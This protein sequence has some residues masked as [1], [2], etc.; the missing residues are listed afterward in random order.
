MSDPQA[1]GQP[2]DRRRAALM[3]KSSMTRGAASRHERS[4]AVFGAIWFCYFGAIGV[5]NPYAPLWFQSL[6]FSTL[7]IGGIASLQ[8]WTRVLAPYAWSWG[9]DHTGRRVELIRLAA[10]GSL[11]SALGLLAVPQLG[12][13]GL[14][15]LVVLA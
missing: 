5:Y 2:D 12:V 7:V 15:E 4:L 3:G 11:L 1:S 8:S 14:S 13:P 6:G 9:G 10:L